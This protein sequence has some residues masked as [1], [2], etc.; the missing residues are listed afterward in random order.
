[1]FLLALL[2]CRGGWRELVI[3][4]FQDESGKKQLHYNVLWNPFRFLRS[5]TLFWRIGTKS[6]V[7]NAVQFVKS[8]EKRSPKLRW[9]L[10]NLD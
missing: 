5:A 8:D 2:L 4:A 1:M 3:A 10:L 7:A 6:S 9:G